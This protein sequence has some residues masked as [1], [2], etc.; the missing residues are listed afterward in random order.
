MELE[1]DWIGEVLSA[2]RFAP[3]LAKTS[4]DLSAAIKLYWWNVRISA[5]FYA[6]LHVLEI[7]LRNA[8]HRQLTVTFGR[9]DWWDVAPL[10]KNGRRKVDDAHGILAQRRRPC[11]ADDTV[12]ELTFGFWVSCVSKAYDRSLW[13]PS[14]HKAFPHYRGPRRRL[15]DNLHTMLLFRNRIMHHEP[16]HHRHLEAD[17][18]TILRLLGHLS[19]TMVEALEAY[20]HV[21]T[22]LGQRPSRNQRADSGGVR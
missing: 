1:P 17:H 4:G 12:A 10:N 18:R 13:V 22:V 20:D 7:A 11:T 14:L 16:I 9:V 19:P 8:L 3:Y 15:H 5:A 2:P 21:D 6:P